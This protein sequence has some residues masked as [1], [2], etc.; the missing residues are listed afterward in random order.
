MGVGGRNRDSR[1]TGF[2]AERGISVVIGVVFNSGILAVVAVIPGAAAPEQVRE[3]AAR[4][5]QPF[6]ASFWSDF[7]NEG[8]LQPNAPVQENAFR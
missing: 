6:S 3:N 2:G 1:V 8:L 7:R 5:G 4:F